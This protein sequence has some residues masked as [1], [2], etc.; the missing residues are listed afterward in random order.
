V[1][2]DCIERAV[3]AGRPVITATQMLESMI[4]HPR[5]TRAEAADVANAVFDGTDAVMLSGETAMGKF[6]VE[7]IGMMARIATASEARVDYAARLGRCQTPRRRTVAEAI[8]HAACDTAIGVDASVIICCTRSGQTAR[9]VSRYRPP[10]PIA[11]V[12]PS[13]ETLRRSMLFWGTVPV[14]APFEKDVI[15]MV[16]HAK[17]AV[18]N[19]GLGREGDRVVVVAGVPIDQP[20]TTNVV[21]ADVL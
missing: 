12:S 10:V 8:A 5:P 4:E 7:A 15:R 11:A 14:S 16:K 20:G 19:A 2:K 1:Q 21:R 9:L 17:E 13:D 3:A 6:P 18:R